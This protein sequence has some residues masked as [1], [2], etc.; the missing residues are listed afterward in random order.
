MPVHDWSKVDAG[1]FHNFHLQ[2]IAEINRAL[3]SGLLPPEYYAMAEQRGANFEADVLTLKTRIAFDEPSPNPMEPQG[4]G[5]LVAEPKSRVRAETDLEFYRRK[6]NIVAVRHASGDDLV[7]VIEI[8]SKGNKSGN[9]VLDDFV[10][11]AA[12]L[13]DHRIH[14]LIADLQPPTS[15][16]PQGIHGRIWEDLTGEAYQA[17]SDKPLTLAAYESG[18]GLVAY[19][20]PVA[21]GDSLI[22]MPLF[23]RPGGHVLVPLEATYQ[24][25]WDV[26]PKRWRDVIQ[27]Q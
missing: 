8:V 20:E 15:R 9:R 10:T 22:D 4:R 14:L 1:V 2:W 11:K 5:I 19:V 25:A 13:I 17:P 12:K 24:A 23:L 21:V 27:P 16:D 7:A 26:V 6:Q 18:S 3:N